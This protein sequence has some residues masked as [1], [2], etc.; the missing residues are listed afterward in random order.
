MASASAG[1]GRS[2]GSM[3]YAYVLK[4]RKNGK[5][6]IGHTEDLQRRITEHNSNKHRTQF[7]ALNGPWKLVFFETFS[8]RSEAMKRERF[9]KSGKGRE[10][11]KK[12]LGKFDDRGV[13]QFGLERCVR[14]AEVAGSS[15][16]APTNILARASAVG[17]RSWVQVPSPRP[18]KE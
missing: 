13:A 17:G 14:D 1:G 16:V 2:C 18:R 10:Y 6:Y 4:S 5:F 3:F 15:P 12:G 11:I 8:T 7:T 9:L